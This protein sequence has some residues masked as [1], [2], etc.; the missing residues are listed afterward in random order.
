MLG[1]HRRHVATLIELNDGIC[2]QHVVDMFFLTSP[3][4]ATTIGESNQ[5][6]LACGGNGNEVVF[7]IT[8]MPD[9]TLDIGLTQ[10]NY[11][12]S[13][14]TRWGGGCPGTYAVECT[15][16]SSTSRH[17][18][19]NDQDS[20]QPVYFAVDSSTDVSGLFTMTWDVTGPSA[21]PPPTPP[22]FV[23]RA[24]IS[25]GT[26]GHSIIDLSSESSPLASTTVDATNGY[27]PS[28]HFGFAN[29]MIFGIVLMPGSSIE[30]GQDSNNFDS[31][32]ELRWGGPCPGENVVQCTDD[33]DMTRHSWTNDQ[34][35]PQAVYFVVDAYFSTEVGSFTLSWIVNGELV[36]QGP[37]PDDID[38]IVHEGEDCWD[39]CNNQQGPCGWCGSG[40]CCRFG[41]HDTS[42]GC[43]GTIG[44]DGLGHVCAP[45]P[46]PEL[47]FD[48]ELFCDDDESDYRG[49]TSTT[50]SGRTCQAWASQT[51]HVHTVTPQ[52][53]PEVGLEGEHNY[54]R[55]PG[56]HEPYSW[57]YTTDPD[58]LW[59]YCDI[60]TA[61]S[62]CPHCPTEHPDVC[63]SHSD[64]TRGSYCDN[65]HHC[66]RC[67]TLSP[68]WCDVVECSDGTNCPAC[69]E[70]EDVWAH[71]DGFANFEQRC[72][73]G[74]PP[75]LFCLRLCLRSRSINAN[76][77][78]GAGTE[79]PYCVADDWADCH[80]TLG[81]A[82][83]ARST[84]AIS[85]DFNGDSL[86]DAFITNAGHQNEL[87]LGTGDGDFTSLM[88]G[89]PLL[90][91]GVAAGDFDGDGISDFLVV[92]GCGDASCNFNNELLLGNANLQPR[93]LARAYDSL[94]IVA[95]DFNN[96][97]LM[98]AFIANNQERNELL[99]ATGDTNNNTNASDS[100]NCSDIAGWVDTDGDGCS[101]YL[102]QGG[103][104]MSHA[105]VAVWAVNGVSGY[106]ACRGTCPEF[107]AGSGGGSGYRYV[108]CWKTNEM[109][110]PD[111]DQSPT[112]IQRSQ[113]VTAINVC[114]TRCSDTFYF[115]LSAGDK[116]TCGNRYGTQGENTDGCGDASSTSSG[117]CADGNAETCANNNAV[118]SLVPV[119]FISTLLGHRDGSRAVVAGDFNKD[120]WTDV[121]VLNYGQQNELLINDG[122]GTFTES[123]LPRSDKSLGGVTGDFDGDGNLDLL[124]TNDMQPNEEL[125]GDG[126]GGFKSTQLPRADASTS[127]ASGQYNADNLT[128]VFVTNAGQPNE[129]LL[130]N[131][132]GS[133][134]STLFLRTDNSRGVVSGHFNSDN[135]PDFLVI[136]TGAV[137]S[138]A[139]ANELLIA[140]GEGGYTSAML[141]SID[142]SQG[143]A[144]ADFNNDNLTDA[145]VVNAYQRNELLL[146]NG[147][148]GFHSSGIMLG[149]FYA[150][151]ASRVMVASLAPVPLGTAYLY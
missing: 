149:T 57:C 129:L 20:P 144:T 95:A 134:S 78:H 94:G 50:T 125:L 41:W 3:H 43:D 2:G 31:V 128:D 124:V 97:G 123:L 104:Q 24:E 9:A 39:E 86:A 64:C 35:V 88:V 55:N 13:Y 98:D 49:A 44:F 76:D 143:A 28:C 101:V 135:L 89:S 26:C 71:C 115:G 91:H 47:E 27:T 146:G 11:D 142:V 53:F 96:D 132:E 67:S 14:E 56:G 147:V 139:Q 116:C 84:S 54:C 105:Q 30:I 130:E 151:L 7:G 16:N 99:I 133:T 51:P 72:G 119:P 70:N 107:C 74:E 62:C 92:N 60:G 110:Q 73:S 17:S 34:E 4:V 75:V 33:P 102:A 42:G 22:P 36:Q 141:N 58:Q 81:D 32:H 65:T 48:H 127:A 1:T 113:L 10:S 82:L 80:L 117:D 136:N 52:N 15:T 45:T 63:R 131:A 112:D 118:Y 61:A 150:Y 93:W 90:S 106:D 23:P 77:L 12:S 18:W 21:P 38:D 148:G 100:L 19:T 69:C 5:H 29:E 114:A 137:E 140:N 138:G 103:C 111:F 145:I 85:G 59:E 46:L 122:T 120:N 8:I 40:I 109:G 37:A 25:V 68:S 6:D 121:V 108:G 66:W 87:L 126:M 79:P 83:D